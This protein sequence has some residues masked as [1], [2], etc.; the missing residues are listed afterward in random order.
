MMKFGARYNTAT[1]PY[2]YGHAAQL[3]L[4]WEFDITKNINLAT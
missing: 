3:L 1:A 4:Q 2:Y